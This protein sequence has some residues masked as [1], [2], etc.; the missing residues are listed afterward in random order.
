M[1]D[2]T[3]L[4]VRVVG[5]NNNSKKDEQQQKVVNHT[6]NIDMKNK[7]VD[8]VVPD[9]EKDNARY[10][11]ALYEMVSTSKM[12][13]EDAAHMAILEVKRVYIDCI[14]DECSDVET[15]SYL[16]G[17]IFNTLEK[18]IARIIESSIDRSSTYTAN[19]YKEVLKGSI[20]N[21]IKLLN[22]EE[23]FDND[24]MMW[25]INRFVDDFNR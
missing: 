17:L 2:F 8:D 15:I 3:G 4:K 20:T 9:S 19:E 10:Y 25:N 18:F 5:G 7:R 22:Y 12:S 14:D 23:T 24:K 16:D 21:S 13:V 6:I 11:K 1:R